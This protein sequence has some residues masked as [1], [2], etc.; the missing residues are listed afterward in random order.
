M[1]NRAD[2][3]NQL[4]KLNGELQIAVSEKRNE[5]ID[6]LRFKIN[7]LYSDLAYLS[8][9]PE[10]V[11]YLEELHLRLLAKLRINTIDI[12]NIIGYVGAGQCGVVYKAVD[13]KNRMN[14]ALKLLLFPRTNEERDRF[15]S[16]GNITYKL[17]HPS[18]VKGIKPTQ[19]LEYLPASW[20]VM[21][22]LE[23]A[24][25]LEYFIEHN[26][27]TNCL[28]ILSKVCDGL[29]YAHQNEVVHRDLHLNN[30]MIIENNSPKILDFGSAKFFNQPITFRPIGCLVTASPEKIID[31][32]KINGKSDVYSIGSILY[33]IITGRWPFISNNY[34]EFVNKIIKS[35]YNDFSCS[36]KK[37]SDLIRSILV[38]NPNDRPTAKELS[39]LLLKIIDEV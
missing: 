3:I 8:E 20:Y 23:N 39:E 9:T 1:N 6:L 36:N 33:K 16:E 30:I 24:K 31:S 29:E 25:S 18:I 14:V 28:I 27:L 26:T 22:L 7:E 34:G 37:I 10:S 11:D 21:E 15:I 5:K 4:Y 38:I 2:Y 17:N 32:G 12:F 13:S 19:N 35:D